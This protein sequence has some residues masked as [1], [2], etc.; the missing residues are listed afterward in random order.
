MSNT[1]NHSNSSSI[2]VSTLEIAKGSLKQS[3][4]TEITTIQEE[5]EEDVKDEHD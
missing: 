2:S 1:P 5:N 3:V 4:S